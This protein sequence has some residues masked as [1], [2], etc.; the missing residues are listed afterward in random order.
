MIYFSL[1]KG[2]LL[3]G[4]E[5]EGLSQVL[6]HPFVRVPSHSQNNL[7]LD[8]DIVSV[9]FEFFPNIVLVAGK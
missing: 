4:F 1:H 3:S 2:N 9:S 5:L 6:D 8:L 7:F